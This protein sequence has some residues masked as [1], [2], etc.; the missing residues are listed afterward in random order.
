MDGWPYLS[1]DHGLLLLVR[2]LRLYQRVRTQMSQRSCPLR[3]YYHH[4]DS[5]C[6][7]FAWVSFSVDRGVGGVGGGVCVLT[8]R[9]LSVC[10]VCVR[11]RVCQ[12]IS[13][14]FEVFASF[15]PDTSKSDVTA[16][17]NTLLRWVKKEEDGL[18]V[19]NA[20]TF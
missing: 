4:E 12:Q 20:P 10:V 13:N 7:V 11:A 9:S 17:V 15:D 1:A 2:I 8:V 14:Q 19:Q 6:T 16:S 18:F 5:L 3:V